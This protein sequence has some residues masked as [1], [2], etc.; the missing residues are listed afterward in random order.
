MDVDTGDGS[1]ASI[2]DR[3]GVDVGTRDGPCAST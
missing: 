3:D 2:K 1:R